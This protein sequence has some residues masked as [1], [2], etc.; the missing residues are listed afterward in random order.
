M[1]KLSADE[2]RSNDTR[3]DRAIRNNSSTKCFAIAK[4]AAGAIC[5]FNPVFAQ[6]I[7]VAAQEA[8]ILRRLLA[9]RARIVEH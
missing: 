9:D 1:L 4:D 8:V 2:F 6:G 5:R 3:C 7:S